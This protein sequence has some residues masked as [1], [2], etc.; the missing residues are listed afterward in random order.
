MFYKNDECLGGAVI[1]NPGPPCQE[2]CIA[3]NTNDDVII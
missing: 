3:F 1:S 2:Q